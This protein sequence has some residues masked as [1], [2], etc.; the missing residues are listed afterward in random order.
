VC[1]RVTVLRDGRLVTTRDIAGLERLDLV[2]LM[3][4]KS[5]E[6]VS[7]GGA[8]GFGGGR[9]AAPRRRGHAAARRR[10]APRAAAA[11]R[12][13]RGARGRDRRGWPGLLGS[14]RT[15]TARAVFGADPADGGELHLNG[16]PL[17]VRT[18][19]DAI[20]AGVAFVSEDRKAEGIIPELSVRENLTLAALP[21]L[22]RF[23]VVDR[24]R[25]RR[26]WTR[27]IAR[28]GIKASSAD[29]KIRELSGGNQQKVLLARWL[30]RRPALLI[31]DEPTRGI[32]IGRQGG[33]PGARQR[34]RG[35]RARGCS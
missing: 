30:C 17:A 1:D 28:L 23:G 15:E 12:V 26:S 22:T 9:A 11:R 2:C 24:P 21:T 6:A 35:R 19:D 25:R 27:F 29:Q 7:R 13:A 33:D 5:R 20:G 10:A 16:R 18:P 32:D 31:L 34:A 8:T 3:L 4:G 14:G